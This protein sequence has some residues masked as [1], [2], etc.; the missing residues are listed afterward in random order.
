[1]Y[2]IRETVSVCACAGFHIITIHFRSAG[3]LE[4]ALLTGV[5]CFVGDLSVSRRHLASDLRT[6]KTRRSSP[7]HQ[8][9]TC[10]LLHGAQCPPPGLAW[11]GLA[12]LVSSYC[13]PLS[14]IRQRYQP[15]SAASNLRFLSVVILSRYRRQSPSK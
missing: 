9:L 11:P 12:W 14:F 6:T 5:S 1:M 8:Q 4:S 10:R 15:Y 7:S 13:W 2:N 3:G